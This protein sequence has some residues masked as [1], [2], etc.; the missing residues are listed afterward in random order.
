MDSQSTVAILLDK[1]LTIAHQYA[2]EV[3]EF[4]D[5]QRRSWEL[6]LKHVFRE[7]NYAA[8]FLANYSH[9]LQRGVSFCF[10]FKL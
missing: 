4:R 7:G 10:Y 1:I 2:L 3:L 6:K 8:D 9:T 5:W